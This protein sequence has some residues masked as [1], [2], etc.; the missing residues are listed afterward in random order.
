MNEESLKGQMNSNTRMKKLLKDE[1]RD[2][3]TFVLSLV[4]WSSLCTYRLSQPS[5]ATLFS[6]Q[7]K[8]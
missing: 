8:S 4:L 1:W 7:S 2:G 5:V 3:R 6:V